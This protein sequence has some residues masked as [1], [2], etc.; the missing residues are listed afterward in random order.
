[1]S[2]TLGKKSRT[3]WQA[4]LTGIR[5]R[6]NNLVEAV[7]D[8]TLPEELVQEKLQKMNGDKER[9]EN[10]LL[11]GK[12]IAYPKI[13]LSKN[14]I[15]NFRQICKE[16]FLMGDIRKRQTFLRSFVKKIDL[17][18]DSCKVHYDL[19]RLVLTHQNGSSLKEGLVELGGIEPPAS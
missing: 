5:K 18:S 7:A 12:V 16:I 14:S 13:N 1:M 2:R 10:E 15:Q 11:Q 9:L 3:S 4:I 17:T 19:A 6:I 8:G